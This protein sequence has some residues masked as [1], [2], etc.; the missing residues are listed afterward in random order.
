VNVTSGGAQGGGGDRQ[1]VTAASDDGGATW[2]APV[3]ASAPGEH[4]REPAPPVVG[5]DGA[6]YTAWR[7]RDAPSSDP[8]PV[9]VAKSTDGGATWTRSMVAQMQPG[10][11]GANNAAGFPRL[12]IDAKA[13]TVYVVYQNFATAGNVDLYVQHSTDGATTWSPPVQVNDD[14]VAASIDHIAGRI[15]VAPNGRLDVVWM[16]GRNAYP[17]ATSLMASPEGDIYYAASSDGGQTFSANRRITD[18]SINLD[19]GLDQRVGSYIWY[20]PSLASTNDAVQFA[21]GDSR[22]GNVDNDNQ[23]IELATLQ[24]NSTVPA[25]VRTLPQ[26]SGSNESVDVSM[27]AYPAGAERIG[28]TATSKVVIVN[29]NDASGALAGAVLARANFGSLL[30]A[31][32]SGLTKQLRDEVAR[33]RPSQAYV[34]GTSATLPAGVEKDLSAVGVKSVK[35]ISGATPEAMAASVAKALDSRSP[36]D[37]TK[38]TAAAP[39]AVVVNPASPD[40][41]AAAGLASSL[42]YPML[43]VSRD[44]VPAA[45]SEALRTLAIPEVLVVGGSGA[46]GDAVVSQLSG[47]T[48]LGGADPAATSVTVAAEAMKRGVPGN[49]I[50]VA[51]QGRPADA[52]LA[53]AAAARAGALLLLTPHAS[54][55]QAQ[56]QIAQ[57]HLTTPVDQIVVVQS[58]SSH[59][60]TTVIIVISIILGVLGLLLLLASLTMRTR[61]RGAP[62]S[63]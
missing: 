3:I 7:N 50:F 35:E 15:A 17:T 28:S 14:P 38:A 47:A 51:D 39:A 48:R 32:A 62:S 49:V 10:P 12:A 4:I 44:S 19:T 20:A 21:W 27:L 54:V 58:K 13:N 22:F 30:L 6:V 8:H 24:I 9:V 5:P 2:G 11:K 29:Q 59:S 61:A 1:L 53:G 63:T 52:A 57:L 34:V 33:L 25:E 40:A 18:R 46:V 26:T 36:D 56:Q 42:G 31:P 23:D 37:V 16:D 43:F 60:A 45:T 55:T 41:A